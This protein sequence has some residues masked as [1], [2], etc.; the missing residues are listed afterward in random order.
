MLQR[1]WAAGILMMLVAVP[2]IPAA[3]ADPDPARVIG[4][5][6]L[7]L[8][9]E[10]LGRKWQPRPLPPPDPA[11]TDADSV[12]ADLRRDGVAEVQYCGLTGTVPCVFNYRKGTRCL[13]VRTR[14]E[15]FPVE[16]IAPHVEAI[17]EEPCSD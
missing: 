16:D 5:G 15:Y 4:M 12:A 6:I 13:T 9:K 2:P 11:I 14:G 10:L 8:R 17:S 3:P 7:E 1:G